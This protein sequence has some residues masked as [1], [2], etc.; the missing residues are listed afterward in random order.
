ME[1]LNYCCTCT[2]NSTDYDKAFSKSQTSNPLH[3]VSSKTKHEITSEKD[4][5]K[6]VLIEELEVG[7]LI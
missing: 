1:K 3:T 2:L 6:T 4:V 7:W 5:R